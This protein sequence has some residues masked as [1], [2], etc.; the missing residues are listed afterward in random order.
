MFPIVFLPYPCQVKKKVPRGLVRSW[1]C[2]ELFFMPGRVRLRLNHAGAGGMRA[3]LL[4][5]GE[6]G[7][8]PRLPFRFRMQLH[9]RRACDVRRWYGG[10]RGRNILQRV[11]RRVLRG[12]RG[13]R[14]VRGLST[15]PRL[16]GSIN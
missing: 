2:H 11:L 1:R 3:R 13:P 14:E 9:E 5:N 12:R 7:L 16:R 6:L 10:A 4:R 15:R 8:L